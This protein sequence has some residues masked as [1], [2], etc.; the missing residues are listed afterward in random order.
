M[1]W[2]QCGYPRSAGI[3]ATPAATPRKVSTVPLRPARRAL[4]IPRPMTANMT[5]LYMVRALAGGCGGSQRS[6]E[7]VRLSRS[8]DRRRAARGSGHARVGK[9]VAWRRG[10]LQ[11]LFCRRG[12]PRQGASSRAR[13]VFQD[14]TIGRMAYGPFRAGSSHEVSVTGR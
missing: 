8:A 14:T 7:P 2:P 13:H 10:P 4:P 9:R 12:R 1:G 11:V 6:C 3:A 5:P